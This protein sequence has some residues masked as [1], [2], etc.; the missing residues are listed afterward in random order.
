MQF[1]GSSSAAPINPQSFHILTNVPKSLKLL[2]KRLKFT[3]DTFTIQIEMEEEV[4]GHEYTL[5]I[6]K[7]D[8]IQFG[9]MEEIGASSIALYIR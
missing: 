7:E 8:I 9:N 2:M 1:S 3:Q 5:Y 6:L 4:L